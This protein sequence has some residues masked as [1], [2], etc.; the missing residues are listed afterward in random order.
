MNPNIEVINSNLLGVRFSWVEAR[1]IADLSYNSNKI[2][3][4]YASLTTDGIIILNKDEEI[5]NAFKTMLDVHVMKYTDER[6]HR[7]IQDM[8]TKHNTPSWDKYI[9]S[10]LFLCQLEQKRRTIERPKK[11]RS[12]LQ[13]LWKGGV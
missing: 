10:M 9:E 2:T 12:W 7:I 13:I 1:L 6:L 5:Y 8:E 4:P 11:P 3:N